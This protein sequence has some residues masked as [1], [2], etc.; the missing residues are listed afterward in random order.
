MSRVCSVGGAKWKSTAADP[1]SFLTGNSSLYVESMYAAW[2]HDPQSV[3]A[4]WRAYFE[5]VESG[6]YSQASFAPAPA[7]GTEPMAAGARAIAGQKDD[8]L[9]ISYLIRAYQV[10]GHEVAQLDPL[11]LHNWRRQGGDI[12]ELSPTFHGF[13]DEEWDRD[14]VLQSSTT[15]GNRGFLD[16]LG[17]DPKGMTVRTVMDN[18]KKTYTQ[19]IGV[20]YMHMNS[21]EKCNWVRSRVE[22]PDFLHYSEEQKLHIYERLSF[23]QMF[24]NFLGHKFN[25]TKRFGLDGGETV[26]PG[27][28]AMVDR[29]SELGLECFVFGMPHRGRLNVLANVLRKDMRQIFKEFKG[30]HFDMDLYDKTGEDWSSSGDVKYHLGTSMDR[31]YPDGRAVHLSLLANPSHL[32]AVNPLVCGKTRAKQFY[33]GDTDAEKRRVMGVILHGDA[34]FAGQ[35]VV[36]ETMQMSKVQDFATGGTIHVVV[37]NQVGFTTDPMNSRSTLYCTDIGKAFDVPIFHVNGDD[38]LAVT[39]AFEMAVEYRQ[40]WGEDC[41]IDLICYRRNGHN[42]LDQPAFTQPL[43][44][45]NISKHP[46]VLEVTKSKF[47]AEGI[48]QEDLDEIDTFVQKQYDDDFGASDAYEAPEDWLSSKWEGIKSPRQ[49]SIVRATGMN[50]GDLQAL[51]PKLCDMPNGFTLH[52]QLKKVLTARKTAIESGENIDWGT[53]EALAFATLLLEGNHVRITGQDVERGTFSHRHAVVHDQKTNEV[54]CSLNNL[55]K[56]V[57][58]AAPLSELALPDTQAKFIARNSILSEYGVLGYEL[59]YSLENPNSL[60]IWEAQFGDFANTAQVMI[61]QFIAAGEDKW[62]RQTGLVM[63]LPHGYDGQG[64]EHSSCRIERYLQSCDD[65]ENI[66]PEMDEDNRMQI[67]QANWQVVNCTTPANYF[68]VLRRQLHRDFRKP[69]VVAAPKKLLRLKAASSTIEDL[70]PDTSFTRVY[71]ESLLGDDAKV[72]RVVLCSGQIYYD[73]LAEREKRGAENVALVRIE[74]VSPFPFDLVAQEIARYPSAEVVF[75]QEEPKNAGPYAYIAPRIM[76]ATREINGEE[77]RARYVGRK[78]SAAPA[79]G[80]IAVHQA[81]TEMIM[82]GVFE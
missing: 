37:N 69:L 30:T 40:H 41:I 2:L 53:A 62:M 36:Y 34:A 39:T 35:G 70:G 31:K 7:P 46:S 28:K 65:D 20:E 25:T 17:R 27:L 73:L 33:M 71:G 55:A 11:G 64:A 21:R 56:A 14:L 10:R 67:Q 68:H 60:C 72:D 80:L 29:G 81:E 63:L 51:A 24:E 22:R 3:H 4:S 79:T 5:S 16:I 82:Q 50:V 23:A 58:P 61:D 6:E 8:S 77:K 54:Y 47:V 26:I 57:S 66:V 13:S 44:Y 32:E 59:G 76:T 74:Q 52:N 15:G 75:C 38:V 9:G 1:D 18:L 42:E 43:L 45:Q 19:G 48:A 78:P 49:K 12:P